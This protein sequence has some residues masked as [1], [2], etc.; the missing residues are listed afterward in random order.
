MLKPHHPYMCGRTNVDPKFVGA[1]DGLAPVG[2]CK[3]QGLRA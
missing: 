3:K 2:A 1:A